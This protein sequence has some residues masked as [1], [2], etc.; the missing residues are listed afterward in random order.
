MSMFGF[1]T[2]KRKAD[3]SMART[4]RSVDQK[5]IDALALRLQSA[6]SDAGAFK[7]LLASIDEDKTLSAAEVIRIASQL[8]GSK[9][10]SRKAALTD[11]AQ[12]RLRV[13]HAKAKGERA[14]KTRLW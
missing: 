5:R 13:A 14:A 2:G 6:M 12:E 4:T 9:P 1:L 3:E 8:V 11:M 10:K 7:A